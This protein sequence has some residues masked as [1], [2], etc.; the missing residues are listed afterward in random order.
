MGATTTKLMTF[1]EFEQLPDEVCRRHELR[2]GE[3]IEVPP[4]KFKHRLIQ[5]RMSALLGSACGGAGYVSIEF[6]FRAL[7]D[8][9]YRTADVV[10]IARERCAAAKGS[11]YFQGAPDMV[12]AVL[13]P[14]NTKAEMRERAALCLANGCLEFWVVDE[15][16]RRVSVSTPNGV[17]ITYHS[18]QTIP[19]RLFGDASLPVD[20]IF[21]E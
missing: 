5:D 17:T 8:G 18:G 16:N 15:K 12:I 11:D 3:L 14:S 2:H 6:G 4:P 1:A 19:L 10:Y 9:E 13:S 21:E 7:P 20:R